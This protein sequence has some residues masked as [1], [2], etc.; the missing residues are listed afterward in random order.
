MQRIP[1]PESSKT[2]YDNLTPVT[3]WAEVPINGTDEFA[4]LKWDD[5]NQFVA[6]IENIT[7][8]WGQFSFKDLDYTLGRTLILLSSCQER[9]ETEFDNFSF[10]D[11]L[12]EDKV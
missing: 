2:V 5:L 6:M 4:I 7:L 12:P 11:F 9:I 10:T 1:L 3:G 8:Y